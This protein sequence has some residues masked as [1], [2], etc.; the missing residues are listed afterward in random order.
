MSRAFGPHA[1]P[2]KEKIM[3]DEKDPNVS[4]PSEEGAIIPQGEEPGDEPPQKD[5][6]VVE[7]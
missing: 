2:T 3:A 7:F 6:I 4:D 1:S 5:G